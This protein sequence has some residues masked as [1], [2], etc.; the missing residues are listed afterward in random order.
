MVALKCQNDITAGDRPG[1]YVQLGEPEQKE[2]G[3]AALAR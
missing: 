3:N 1:F 2:N